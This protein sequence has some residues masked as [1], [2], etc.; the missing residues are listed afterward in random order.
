M[1]YDCV[2]FGTKDTTGEIISFLLSEGKIINL[3]ITISKR[4]LE[5]NH[6][7]GYKELLPLAETMG[8]SIF[9]SESYSL[10]DEKTEEFFRE[11]TFN[12]G[13]CMGWQRLIPQFIL[14]RFYYGIFG[15]H[16]SCAYL[17]Y[18]RG[19]SPLNW[20][21]ING[22][23][24]YI[25][26]LFQYDEK[27]DSPNV[28]AQEMFEINSFDTIRTLQYK[29]IIC[30]KRM[31]IQLLDR[32]E[33]GT[34]CIKKG[35]KDYD[36][37]YSKRTPQDGKICFRMKTR[38]IYNLVRG[39]TKPFPGAYILTKNKKKVI[40][41]RVAPFDQIIDFSQYSPGEVINCFDSYPIIRTID[42][43]LIIYEYEGNIQVGDIFI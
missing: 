1:H 41:W 36:T 9:E 22:D 17:P 11:N 10:T 38:Q 29:N 35:G 34:I 15:F 43:S 5:K 16:G 8:I 3:I 28:F 12:I 18:G 21:I 4:V 23:T 40:L 27:A 6:V 20:S 33:K 39:V 31:I 14:E 7:S 42:G 2:V 26:N 25:L 32:Y 30:A 37:W 13:I 24:R 19:R